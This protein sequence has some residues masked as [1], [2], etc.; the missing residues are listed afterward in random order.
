MHKK[1]KAR[2]R[3]KILKYKTD[4]DDKLNRGTRRR[5]R[6]MKNKRN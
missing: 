1:R 2:K 3:K 6:N 4:N 5:Y